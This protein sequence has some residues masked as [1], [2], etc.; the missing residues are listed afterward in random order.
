MKKLSIVFFLTA[1]ITLILRGQQE[2]TLHFAT[3]IWQSSFTNPAFIP[4][5]KIVVALPSFY[6]NYTSP[7]ATLKDIQDV[8][9]R[10]S[11][12]NKVSGNI[13]W[14]TLG[15]SF[16]LS[17]TLHLNVHHGAYAY[18]QG[19][20]N[21]NLA[22][23]YDKGNAQFI[24]QTVDFASS[25]TTLLYNE[26]AIGLSY[27]M[28]ESL[29]LGL[30]VKY[31]A[32]NSLSYYDL[33]KVTIGFDNA[34]YGLTFN[35]DLN[36]TTFSPYRLDSVKT[37][38]GVITEQKLFT[39]NTG[40]AIDLGGSMRLGKIGFNVSIIDLGA[41]INWKNEGKKS[42][43][44]GTF[45]YS[46]LK[47]DNFF[48]FDSLSSSS[49]QD[50]LKNVIGLVENTEGVTFR[51]RLPTKVYL[52]STYDLSD[53]LKLGTLL[54][55]EFDAAETRLGFI[56][57]AT[58]Q[59]YDNLAVGGSIGLRNG[60][61]DN[62]GLSVVSKFGLVQVYVV[63]DNIIAAFKPNDAKNSNGRLGINLVF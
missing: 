28:Q 44:K 10:L 62:V 50:T 39:T 30:R 15:V 24:G 18:T 34:N 59:W 52:S 8:T 61:F 46:G 55:T 31:L 19:N 38:L 56:A 21:R 17:S 57:N 40:F 4:K 33:N 27:K 9:T 32:G 14:Q 45:T 41:G 26:W 47:T 1:F 49:F 3:D 23:L 5:N 36:I 43:S 42:V 6:Y 63:S 51:Q 54:F 13:S 2:Q 12:L 53:D 37:G 22:S 48:K 60:V 35:N 25:L 58:Y 29:S 20:I 16:P 7:N 11:P